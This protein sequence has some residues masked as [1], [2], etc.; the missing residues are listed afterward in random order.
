[1]FS[2]EEREPSD[3]F[4]RAGRGGTPA[5]RIR[6]ERREEVP[7]PGR[8]GAPAP[9]AAPR[10]VSTAATP[11]APTVGAEV[12]SSILSTLQAIRDTLGRMELAETPGNDY[13]TIR[14]FTVTASVWVRFVAEN[15]E[16]R[17]RR[18]IVRAGAGVSVA[19]SNS[20]S[21]LDG[22]AIPAADDTDLGNIGPKAE[23]YARL[24]AAGVDGRIIVLEEG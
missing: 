13:V 3:F 11:V 9:R 17:T 15:T 5:L 10:A 12:F 21:T 23:L 8:P 16:G 2:E 6:E 14:A 22:L 19:T 18:V 1:M 24:S 4:D 7:T 20:G